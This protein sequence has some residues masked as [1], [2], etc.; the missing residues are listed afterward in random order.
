MIE[1]G[2]KEDPSRLY[3][4]A[5]MI[6]NSMTKTPEAEA[7]QYCD[8]I[9]TNTYGNHVKI[10]DNI[11][12]LYPDKPILIS[13]WG[14][15]ADQAT[16]AGQVKHI[17]EVARIIRDR[18]YIIGASWWSY[19]D[20]QSRHVGTNPSG[21]RPW[22]L[23]T[24]DRSPRPAYF[25]YQKEMSPI[26]LKVMEINNGTLK[27]QLGIKNDFPYQ[28]IKNYRL[29]TAFGEQLIPS[30]KPGEI[31]VV[32]VKGVTGDAVKIEVLTP[33]KFVIYQETVHYK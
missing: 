2:R 12:S 10:F 32:E 18:P 23:V 11:H 21:Y 16:E 8:F 4:F 29:K 1:F 31:T 15:R 27:L 9:S 24:A 25:T 17:E 28:S 6:L 13:E 7:S 14:V 33:T 19:N 22:G 20:Y 5:T 30:L 26:S 3:T